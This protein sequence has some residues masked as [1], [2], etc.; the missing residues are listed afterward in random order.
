MKASTTISK[1]YR[2]EVGGAHSMS[3]KEAVRSEDYTS[4]YTLCITTSR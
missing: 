3:E 2:E 1:S 4:I